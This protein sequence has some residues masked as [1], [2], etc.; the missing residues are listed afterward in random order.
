MIEESEKL[1][2]ETESK[3]YRLADSLVPYSFL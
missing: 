2:S 1:K 3:A